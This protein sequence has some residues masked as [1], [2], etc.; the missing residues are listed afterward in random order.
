M[1]IQRKT[2]SYTSWGKSKVQREVRV[3]TENTHNI[4]EKKSGKFNV[5]KLL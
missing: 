1:Y 4:R 5:F 3:R 2:I